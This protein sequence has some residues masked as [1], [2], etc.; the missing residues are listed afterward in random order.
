M[1][2]FSKKKYQK[3]N[4]GIP[5]GGKKHNGRR[6]LRKRHTHS[7]LLYWGQRIFLALIGVSAMV[8]C[9]ALLFYSQAKYQ[10]EEREIEISLEEVPSIHALAH[11]LVELG[12][13]QGPT[14]L[15]S[16][17]IAATGG[18]GRIMKGPHFFTNRL[19][20]YELLGR[21]RRSTWLHRVKITI[22]EGWTRFDIARLLHEHRV[23]SSR[24]FLVA[25]LDQALLKTLQI[26]AKSAEGYLF[27]ATY[28]FLPNSTPQQLIMRMKEEFNFRYRALEA[29]RAPSE[30]SS[31]PS[32]WGMHAI[33][34]LASIIEKEAA[35]DEERGLIASV[36]LNRL[37][38]PSFQPKLLQSDATAGYGCLT[39][40]Q[41]DSCTGYKG[42]I[43]R[44]I[45]V[46]P[47][48]PYNTYKHEGLPPGPIS[49]PGA[50]SLEA[51]LFPPSS[52]F[53][54]FV[55]RGEGRHT[56]ST[57]YAEHIDAI[58]QKNNGKNHIP[59]SA[60]P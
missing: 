22:P 26:P 24:S 20:P 59:S 27:P 54:Y 46:D 47:I 52:P 5:L 39:S 29:H 53:F 30:E 4:R 40:P 60:H 44:S 2:P 48:N 32:G 43:K 42:K 58:R 36:F 1:K 12:A 18:T 19:S 51:T 35:V 9:P 33:V 16:L 50:K 11:Q 45:L 3:K 15:L 23:C 28:E 6:R 8:F 38:S 21:L 37:V 7:P 17:Y 34:T 10:G 41:L 55:S 56:F 14:P 25:T 49:N 57:T 31:H 13:A